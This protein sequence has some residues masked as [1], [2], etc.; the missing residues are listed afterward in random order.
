MCKLR[1]QRL[2]NCDTLRVVWKSEDNVHVCVCVCVCVC[3][4][5]LVC[6]FSVRSPGKHAVCF[7]LQIPQAV[8]RMSHLCMRPQSTCP[9]LGSAQLLRWKCHSTEDNDDKKKTTAA[10]PH[11]NHKVLNAQQAVCNKAMAHAQSH[12]TRLC[13]S[14]SSV[15]PWRGLNM[16][17]VKKR[18]KWATPPSSESAFLCIPGKQSVA[19]PDKPGRESVTWN[20][21]P[22][23]PATIDFTTPPRPRW[24]AGFEAWNGLLSR[25][26]SP[27]TL[28]LPAWPLPPCICCAPLSLVRIHFLISGPPCALSTRFILNVEAVLAGTRHCLGLIRRW[29]KWEETD[30]NDPFHSLT[31]SPLTHLNAISDPFICTHTHT[32]TN[33]FFSSEPH[34]DRFL[35]SSW[36][37]NQLYVFFILQLTV[38]LNIWIMT[39]LCLSLHFS[40]T[41][42]FPLFLLPVSFGVCHCHR[43]CLWCA[44]QAQSR[45]SGWH[46]DE[47]VAGCT[48]KS[49]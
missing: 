31:V 45:S 39:D 17:L 11:I 42:L 43:A 4:W 14:L 21:Q 20:R 47:A 33:T 46:E 38:K 26:I 34:C 1:E 30:L 44:P 48:L 23:P 29:S 36:N 3:V 10:G 49:N 7:S 9:V 2:F 41:I 28:A 15:V 27:H 24:S 40:I 32:H 13:V 5:L 16:L 6:V 19:R 8:R 12:L 18:R 22:I 25:L 37:V 35:R